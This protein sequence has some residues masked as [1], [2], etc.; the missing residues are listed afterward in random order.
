MPCNFNIFNFLEAYLS[1]LPQ[2]THQS[3][4][5]YFVKFLCST[6][7]SAK[8]LLQIFQHLQ[9]HRGQEGVQLRNPQGSVKTITSL[10]M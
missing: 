6:E 3:S 5:I 8:L 7:M 9:M 4:A 10:D 1:S 2:K